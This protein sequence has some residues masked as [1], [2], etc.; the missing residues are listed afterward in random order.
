MIGWFVYGGL[1]GHRRERGVGC[2]KV[3]LGALPQ[4]TARRSGSVIRGVQ[5]TGGDDLCVA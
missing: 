2:G 4:G 5:Q 3:W 1:R